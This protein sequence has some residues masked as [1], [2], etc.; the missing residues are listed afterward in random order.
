MV[1]APSYKQNLVTVNSIRK[2]VLLL[3]S[4][5]WKAVSSS[6]SHFNP[7]FSLCHGSGSVPKKLYYS[8]LCFSVLL[9][10]RMQTEGQVRPGKTG[11]IWERW[12]MQSGAYYMHEPCSSCTVMIQ[13]V[14]QSDKQ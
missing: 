7:E 13:G 2:Y 1:Y 3:V 4:L 14:S 5:T 8:S 11:I 12:T 6:L 10:C 9:V